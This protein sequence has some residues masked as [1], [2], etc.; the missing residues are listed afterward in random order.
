MVYRCFTAFRSGI[1]VGT[2]MGMHFG[3]IAGH[4]SLDPIVQAL[5]QSGAE[6]RLVKTLDRLEDAPNDGNTTYIIAGEHAGASYLL[7]ET[8]VLSAGQADLLAAAANRM[9]TLVVGCG[10]ETVSGT[11]WFSAFDGP[12]VLRMFFMCRSNLAVP[13]SV[14]APFRS[15]ATHPLDM[16]WDGDGIFAAFTELGFDYTAWLNAGPYQLFALDNVAE[17]ANQPLESAQREHW[18]HNQLAPET[19]PKVSIVQRPPVDMASYQKPSG[20]RT[21]LQGIRQ[22]FR[23]RHSSRSPKAGVQTLFSDD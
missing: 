17:L 9:G 5:R 8:M 21:L 19:R 15:E 13:F 23:R 16:D 6:L 18:K 7:D 11:F 2:S 3:I 4:V 22:Y 12:E 10:A 1:W 20:R 14:G